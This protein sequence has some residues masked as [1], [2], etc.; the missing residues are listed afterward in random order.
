MSTE[1]APESLRIPAP[2][3]APEGERA[4]RG[5]LR[6]SRLVATS[7]LVG[8]GVIFVATHLI[9]NPG[10]GTLLIQ[11]GAQAG[12]VGGVA[13]WFAVTALFRHPFGLPIPHTAI[14]PKNKDRIGRTI[15]RFIER[16]FLTREALLPKFREL[17]AG[18]RIA[19]WL[20]SPT[21]SPLIAGSLSAVLPRIIRSLRHPD[22]AE[23]LQRMA[24]DQ[25][26]HVDVAPLVARALALLTASGEADILLDRISEAALAWIEK[27]RAQI[28]RLVIERSRWWIPRAVD[29]RVAKAIADGLTEVLDGLR[30]PSSGASSKFRETV[31]STVDELLNSPEQRQKL[32][33][34][35]RRLLTHPEARSW[36]IS[37]F[38]E[39]CET[40]LEDLRQ[41]SSRLRTGLEKPISVMAEVLGGDVVMQ[42][43]VDE[44]VERAAEALIAWRSE[45]GAFVTEVVRKWD[46]PTLS[47]RLELVV[48]SDL[49]FIRMNGTL[50]GAMAGSVIFT[51]SYLCSACSG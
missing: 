6:R 27:N 16:N 26:A 50:V 10:F 37:V 45:I 48:G 30:R 38:H 35:A 14:I 23:F 40:A 33:A 51:L 44:M 7:M 17:H 20:A 47:D 9:A 31:A 13:D 12:M 29:R 25:L 36:L 22:L 39:L 28:D 2:L 21:T 18:A 46:T 4:S 32:N 3:F 1:H 11:S 5:R 41:P 19:D 24:S 43:H 15:G 42:Q 34:G 49:Q 8:M